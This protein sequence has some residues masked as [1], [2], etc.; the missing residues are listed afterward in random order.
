[1][2]LSCDGEWPTSER[3][4]KLVL[5][6]DFSSYRLFCPGPLVELKTYVLSHAPMCVCVCVC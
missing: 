5:K 6:A 2:L 4:Q 1:M 3:E